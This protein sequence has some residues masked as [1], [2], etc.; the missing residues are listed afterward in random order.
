MMKSRKFSFIILLIL[1]T[2]TE[3]R[4]GSGGGSIKEKEGGAEENIDGLD[5]QSPGEEE[6]D[7]NEEKEDNEEEKG[8]E[9]ELKPMDR[10][11][12]NP[13][14]SQKINELMLHL[15]ISKA[16]EKGGGSVQGEGRAQQE[17]T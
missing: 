4:G 10:A 6:K 12:P 9:D 16:S 1:L 3:G 5:T 15:G 7:E 17:G 13:R 14:T 11:A 8:T 2:Y